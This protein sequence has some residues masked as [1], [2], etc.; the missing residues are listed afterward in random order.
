MS[1]R[2]LSLAEDSICDSGGQN[3]FYF[4]GYIHRTEILGLMTNQGPL[5]RIYPTI[6]DLRQEPGLNDRLVVQVSREKCKARSPW[7]VAI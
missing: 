6:Y 5:A 4:R 7:H 2:E 1:E 3:S